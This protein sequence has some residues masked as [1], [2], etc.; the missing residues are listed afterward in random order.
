[1]RPKRLTLRHS[2]AIRG[3]WDGKHPVRGSLWL[4][5]EISLDQAAVF[6]METHWTCQIDLH[7][8]GVPWP[9]ERTR[10]GTAGLDTSQ[11][12]RLVLTSSLVCWEMSYYA[13]V[14]FYMTEVHFRECQENVYWLLAIRVIRHAPLRYLKLGYYTYLIMSLPCL[15]T[16]CFI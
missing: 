2:Q 7:I 11:P 10:F 1:M 6:I 12:D 3:V 14:S 16:Y 8:N 4:G 13:Q 15:L 9:D 5:S